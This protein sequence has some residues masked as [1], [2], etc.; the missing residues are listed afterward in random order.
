LETLKGRVRS[1]G[2]DLAADVLAL[3][4]RFSQDW[5]KKS[6]ALRDFS[7]QATADAR[8]SANSARGRANDDANAIRSGSQH[9][10]KTVFNYIGNGGRDYQQ[11]VDAAADRLQALTQTAANLIRG[12][13]Q[14]T[15]SNVREGSERLASANAAQIRQAGQ[16]INRPLQELANGMQTHRHAMLDAVTNPRPAEGMRTPSI[17]MPLVDRRHSQH[18][19]YSQM[20]D[21]L[22]AVQ[23][24]GFSSVQQRENAAAALT[25]LAAKED[26]KQVSSVTLSKDGTRLIAF[27]GDPRNPATNRVDVTLAQA[28]LQ[29]FEQSSQQA[30]RAALEQ[31][32]IQRSVS[33]GMSR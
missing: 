26:F 7:R 19:I 13:H 32:D 5:Q 25:A 21:K 1:Q 3:G 31:N 15:A 17:V 2:F 4:G 16:T 29:N 22:G 28:K 20:H 23:G 8:E 33:Q 27:D 18:A 11:R 24:A 30:A 6:E 12:Q 10:S 14:Q 9:Q